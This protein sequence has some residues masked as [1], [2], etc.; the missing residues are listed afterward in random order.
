[1]LDMAAPQKYLKL[2]VKT[3]ETRISMSV[4][5]AFPSASK[6]NLPPSWIRKEVKGGDV[7][8]ET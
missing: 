2:S 3:R 5:C 4:V 6:G 7:S 8:L 1:M